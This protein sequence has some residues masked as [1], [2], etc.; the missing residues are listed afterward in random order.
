M[1]NTRSMKMEYFFRLFCRTHY[2]GKLVE[3][4]LIASNIDFARVQLSMFGAISSVVTTS[5]QK[6]AFV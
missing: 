4:V 2:F 3:T 1:F 6:P 5:A